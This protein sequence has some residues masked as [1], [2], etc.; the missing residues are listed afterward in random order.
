M[1]LP[2][3]T[4]TNVFA[5]NTDVTV[6]QDGKL[7]FYPY[8]KMKLNDKSNNASDVYVTSTNL[9]SMPAYIKI[10]A[11][12][13]KGNSVDSDSANGNNPTPNVNLTSTQWSTHKSSLEF[14]S[15]NDID[16]KNVVL[17]G[18]AIFDVDMKRTSAPWT[19]EPGDTPTTSTKLGYRIW[20]TCVP[21]ELA[22]ALAPGS[23][24]PT[25]S[26]AK[27]QVTAFDESVK[28]SVANYGLVQ[29]VAKG[30]TPYNG[31]LKNFVGDSAYQYAYNGASWMNI[32]LSEDTKYYLKLVAPNSGDGKLRGH[33]ILP[34]ARS[35]KQRRR[36]TGYQCIKLWST[37]RWPRDPDRIQGSRRRRRQRHSLPE[38]HTHQDHQQ[39]AG[40]RSAVSRRRN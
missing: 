22:S 5:N 33:K 35:T 7:D 3:Q 11:G 18:G 40:C 20:Q 25:V 13:W 28:N 36:Q 8:I 9:S 38:Q 4:F 26:E 21:D 30:I 23:T 32:T 31:Y 15:D 34:Q 12:L 17:P 27:N 14:I 19:G 16:D 2:D 29:A 10:E 39:N 37:Q 24:A 6:A 1:Q